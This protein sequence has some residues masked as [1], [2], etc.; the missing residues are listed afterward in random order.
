[1][2]LASAVASAVSNLSIRFYEAIRS[3]HAG[4]FETASRRGF[5]LLSGA[6]FALVVTYRSNGEPV[7]TPVWF[8]I[9]GE[10]LYF[11]SVAG[12]AKLRRIARNPDVL[13]AP[14]TSNGRPTGAATPGTATVLTDPRHCATAEGAIRAS[15]GLSRR[16]YMRLIG[17]RVAG[18]Y[19]EVDP[20]RASSAA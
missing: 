12:A 5:D 6:T 3:K 20:I 14:C 10:R 17:T 15:Y 1:M 16:I 18:V 2:P 8:G 13:V 11:R 9:S 19:V 4:R 7:P